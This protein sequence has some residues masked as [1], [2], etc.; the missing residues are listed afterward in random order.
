MPCRVLFITR[1]TAK[2][3]MN[4]N[5][6]IVWKKNFI[7]HDH[8]IL[9]KNSCFWLSELIFEI[10]SEAYGISILPFQINNQA[11]LDSSIKTI[12]AL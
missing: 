10:P 1:T 9:S 2:C 8:F 5:C 7:L 4:T 12:H 11:V 6:R 3:E